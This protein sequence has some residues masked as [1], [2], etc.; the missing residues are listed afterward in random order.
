MVPKGVLILRPFGSKIEWVKVTKSISKS[1][2]LILLFN[3]TIFKNDEISIFFSLN[4]SVRS[5]AV[6]GVANN[7]HLRFGQIC[8]T[9]PMWSSWAC[10]S[11]IPNK[12]SFL[13]IMK[14]GSGIIKSMP[15]I[16][17]SANV[18]PMSTIIHF[19]LFSFP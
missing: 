4:F 1:P 16:E 5:A 17:S 13:S 8:A 12:S 6:K 14:P 11:T 3:G 10:V 9:A 19:W 2:S 18:T 15:G 7:L